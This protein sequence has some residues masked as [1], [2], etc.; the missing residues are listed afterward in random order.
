MP[1]KVIDKVIHAFPNSQP[2]KRHRSCM[3]SYHWPDN[4]FITNSFF[5]VFLV[6]YIEYTHINRLFSPAV[7]KFQNPKLE[8]RQRFI[9]IRF[10]GTLIYVYIFSAQ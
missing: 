1:Y 9:L 5:R 3:Y 6:V 7:I 2:L 10:K 4:L 8:S